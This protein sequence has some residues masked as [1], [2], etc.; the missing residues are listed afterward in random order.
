M[1]FDISFLVK[2]IEKC[3]CSSVQAVTT[4]GSVQEKKKSTQSL[5]KQFLM[6]SAHMLN[7]RLMG[8]DALLT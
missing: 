7:K 6:F 8:P 1:D 5:I 3:F 2:I 4:R